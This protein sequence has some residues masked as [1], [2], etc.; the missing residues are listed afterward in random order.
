MKYARKI[1]NVCRNHAHST[2]NAIILCEHVTKTMRILQKKK[3][4]K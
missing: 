2:R 1:Y 4:N 3:I